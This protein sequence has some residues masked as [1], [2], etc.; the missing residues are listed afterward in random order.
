MR[1]AFLACM[2]TLGCAEHAGPTP[3]RTDLDIAAF[4]R[5]A[6]PVLLRDCSFAACHGGS[7]RPFQVYG[8]GRTRLDPTLQ[9]SAPASQLELKAS[10]ARAISMLS[11]DRDVDRSLLL[12]KPLATA[13]GG[14]F[15]GGID[16]LGRNVYSSRIDPGYVALRT[17]SSG[18]SASDSSA[19][20]AGGR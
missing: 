4:E 12:T 1:A 15:H 16:L 14:Q 11:T 7:V 10:Y 13:A 9:P 5:L 17:W 6:Y 8:P 18:E 20:G 2:L 3:L 19:A